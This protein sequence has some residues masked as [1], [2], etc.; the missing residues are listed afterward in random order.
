M[1]DDRRVSTVAVIGLGAMGARIARRL[2]EDGY[3]IV[4]WNRTTER[5]AELVQLGAA[6]AASPADAARRAGAVLTMVSDP[7]ALRAVTEGPSG[8]AA[9]VG[10]SVTVIEMSTVGPAAVSRLMSLLPAGTALLDAPV[11]GSLAEAESGS[12]RIFVGGPAS[13]VEQWTP[14][15]VC[16]RLSRPRRPARCRCG[17]QAGRQR[18][19]VW[20]P[21]RSRRSS[22]A[23][24][25]TG[26]VAGSGL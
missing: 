7:A 2:L 15:L 6:P 12:L 14:L 21:L 19:A 4:V 25:R 10:A 11:L 17:G 20:S 18:N 13:L 16:A 26:L 1:E 8:V 22:G 5:A 24:R 23:R 3:D 9:G